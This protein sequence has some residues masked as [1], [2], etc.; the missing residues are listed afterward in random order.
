M[1][2]YGDIVMKAGNDDAQRDDAPHHPDLSHL[3][4]ITITIVASY[5]K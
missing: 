2:D 5:E 1:T 3:I 4:T